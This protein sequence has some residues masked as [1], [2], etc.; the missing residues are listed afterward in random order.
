[1]CYTKIVLSNGEKNEKE[2]FNGCYECL[3]DC[4]MYIFV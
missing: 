3:L 2:T 4:T 1:M